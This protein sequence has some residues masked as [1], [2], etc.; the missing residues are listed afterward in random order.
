MKKFESFIRRRMNALIALAV[1]A[2]AV[3]AGIAAT[4]PSPAPGRTALLVGQS[5]LGS[6]EVVAFPWDPPG[7][8]TVYI[9]WGAGVSAGAVIVEEMYS[10][11][12]TGTAAPIQTVTFS[13]ANSVSAVHLNSPVGA[14]Q[15]RISTAITGGT[16]NTYA[17]ASR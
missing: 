10:P 15:T 2:L 9:E 5:V 1:L 16:V 8:V 17:V 14:I 6:K 13:A 3:L 11:T 4:N 7:G 12:F